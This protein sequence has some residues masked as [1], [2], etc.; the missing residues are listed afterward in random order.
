MSRFSK[1]FTTLESTLF[2]V[3]DYWFAKDPNRV[4][5]MRPDALGKPLYLNGFLACL[6]IMAAQ[7]VNL[8][9]IHPYG[10]YLVVDD[11]GGIVVAGVL[12]K[13]GG[14]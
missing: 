2:H 12:E 3:A 14:Q 4:L 5:G 7:M 9:N 13:L 6:S 10:R 11:G 8:A 1:T